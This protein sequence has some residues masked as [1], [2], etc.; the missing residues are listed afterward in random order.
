MTAENTPLA[1]LKSWLETREPN[2]QFTIE[3][4]GVGIWTKE[5]YYTITVS[6]A[7]RRLGWIDG[8]IEHTLEAK[9]WAEWTRIVVNLNEPDSFERIYQALRFKP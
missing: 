2:W 9:V 4:V 1:L 5:P 8:P 3:R 6:D 7:D